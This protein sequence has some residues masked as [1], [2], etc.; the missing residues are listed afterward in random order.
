MKNGGWNEPPGMHA[1]RKLSAR[2]KEENFSHRIEQPP[3]DGDW[4]DVL[5]QSMEAGIV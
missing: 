4:N 2:L 1:A 3:Q 5:K